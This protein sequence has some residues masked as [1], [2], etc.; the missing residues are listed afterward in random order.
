MRLCQVPLPPP[1]FARLAFPLLASG[2]FAV[3]TAG[4]ERLPIIAIPEYLHVAPVWRD[5]VYYGS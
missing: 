1:E 3:V 5:M 4:A 2:R